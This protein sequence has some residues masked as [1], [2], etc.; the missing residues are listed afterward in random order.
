MY[1]QTKGFD[2]NT[3]STSVVHT[4]FQICFYCFSI[5]ITLNILNVI[6]DLKR[7]SVAQGLFAKSLTH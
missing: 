4:E 1:F 2:E 5:S 3:G 6:K 7:V